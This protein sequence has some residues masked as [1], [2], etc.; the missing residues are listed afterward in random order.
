MD[1]GTGRTE[2]ERAEQGTGV[3]GLC[4]RMLSADKSSFLLSHSHSAFYAWKTRR[5]RDDA[6]RLIQNV[7]RQYNQLYGR[8]RWVCIQCG[9]IEWLE[10]DCSACRFGKGVIWSADLSLL[11]QNRRRLH[12]VK[13][14]TCNMDALVINPDMNLS[15]PYLQRFPETIRCEHSP[16]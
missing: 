5:D 7:Y 14:I 16:M 12:R 11:M 4:V 2:R 1:Q 6:V 15:T 10:S 8:N 13:T 3:H 9:N